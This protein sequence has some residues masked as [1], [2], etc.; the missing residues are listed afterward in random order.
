[1]A[2]HVSVHVSDFPEVSTTA[3]QHYSSATLRCLVLRRLVNA[4]QKCFGAEFLQLFS[5]LFIT[6]L[7]IG[8]HTLL[9]LI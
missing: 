3:C 6:A 1:M 2:A 9:S 5:E 7:N 4:G 8:L